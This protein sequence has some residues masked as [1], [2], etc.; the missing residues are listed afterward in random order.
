MPTGKVVMRTRSARRERGGDIAPGFPRRDDRQNGPASSARSRG[1][2]A[3]SRLLRLALLVGILVTGA[4]APHDP[5]VDAAAHV[6]GDVYALDLLPSRGPA[7]GGTRVTFHG[8]GF[9][10]DMACQFGPHTIHPTSVS[11]EGDK[12]VCVTPP[13]G[14][15]AGG[16][17]AVGITITTAKAWPETPQVLGGAEGGAEGKGR[18]AVTPRGA[19]SFEYAVAWVLRS[20]A[21]SRTDSAGG[22]V[23]WATGSHLHA[24]GSCRFESPASNHGGGS[25]S[26]SFAAA[27]VVSSA[28]I[29]CEAPATEIGVGALAVVSENPSAAR[30]CFDTGTIR[31]TPACPGSRWYPAARPKSTESS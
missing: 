27:R 26:S 5:S 14:R 22:T 18:P 23:V 31:A 28:L 10:T 7:L 3:P 1:I 15:P 30:R 25:S 29:A 13:F 21:P 19:R 20:V 12:L 6:G 16:F 4:A 2:S 9:T 17:I 24:A 8:R 11:P